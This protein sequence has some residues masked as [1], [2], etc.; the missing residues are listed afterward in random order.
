MQKKQICLQLLLFTLFLA[1]GGLIS[2]ML[3]FELTY[4]L[5]LYHHYN[6]F[7]FLNNR[8]TTDIAPECCPLKMNRT[9]CI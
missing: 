6:G 4:D 7:A 2:A 5:L 1:A 9:N 3:R 8:L